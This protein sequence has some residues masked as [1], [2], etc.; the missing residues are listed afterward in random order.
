[1]TSC[2]EQQTYGEPDSELIVYDRFKATMEVKIKANQ[3]RT[4]TK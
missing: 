1:L 4:L 3:P 2:L